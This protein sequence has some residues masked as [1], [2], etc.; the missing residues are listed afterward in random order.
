MQREVHAAR[1]TWRSILVE[2]IL[3]KN[4]RMGAHQNGSFVKFIFAQNRQTLSE[5]CVTVHNLE[6]LASLEY[7]KLSTGISNT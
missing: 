4:F 7:E 6:T 3:G 5:N 2:Q 1:K